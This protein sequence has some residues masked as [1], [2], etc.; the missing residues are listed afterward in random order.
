MSKVH[1]NR[2]KLRKMKRHAV[3]ALAALMVAQTAMTAVAA[4][5]TKSGNTSIEAERDNGRKVRVATDSNAHYQDK[6]EEKEEE[7]EI[8]DEDFLIDD[9]E[10]EDEVKLATDSNARP[11][12]P[13]LTPPEKTEVDIFEEMPEIGTKEFTDWFFENKTSEDLWS[14]VEG[15]LASEDES[16]PDYEAF[17]KW[18]QV[19]EQRVLRAYRDYS[20]M[21]LLASSTGDL[22]NGWQGNTNWDGEGT[23]AFPYE[24]NELSD[25]CGLSEMVAAGEDFSGKYF[26]LTGDIDLGN[27][28]ANNGNWNPIG[29]YQNRKDIGKAVTNKFAGN[30]DGAGYS[31]TGMRIVNVKDT[32]NN[33]G[34]FGAVEG[35]S[36][37]NLTVE[38]EISSAGDNVGILAGSV[39]EDT[40]IYNVKVEN[41]SISSEGDAGGLVGEVTGKKNAKSGTVTFENCIADGIIINSRADGGYVGGIAGNV[42]NANIV[43]CEVRTYDGNSDRIQGSGYIGGIAGRMR[44]SNLFNVYVDGTI[45]GSGAQ[46]VGGIVGK[47]ESGDLIL[48]RFAGTISRTNQGTA[49]RE[50]TFVGTRDAKDKFTYGV[51]KNDNIAY[52]FTDT[53]AKAKNVFG[54]SIDKDN[55]FTTDAHIGYWEDNERVFHLVAG[56]VDKEVKDKFFYEELED[57]VKHIIV[58]KH[59]NKVSIGADGSYFD[60]VDYKLDHFAPNS[61]GAPIKGYL[62]SIPR[63]DTH[64]ADGT[65]DSDVATLTAIGQTANSYYRQIDMNN[66]S[67]VAP[68]DT[69]LVGTAPKNKGNNKYQMVYDEM[70][71]GKVKPPTYTDEDGNVVDMAYQSGGSYTFTMPESD[72]ELNV[73]YIKVTTQLTMTP[74]ETTLKVVQ[75]R[76]GDRKNP[77]ITT[78]VYDESGKQIAKYLGDTEQVAPNPV[79]VTAT[80]NGE[81]SAN[82]RTV[83]WSIDNADLVTLSNVDTDTYTTKDAYIMPN[84]KS[85]F[86]TGIINKKVQEQVDS[87]YAEAIDNTVYSDVAT[88]TA[89]TNP[90]TSVNNIPVVGNTRVNVTF[91]IVDNTTRRVEGLNLNQTNATITVTRKL[92]GDRL[93]PTETIASDEATVLAASLYPE[94]P[95]N[96]NVTWKWDDSFITTENTGDHKENLSVSVRFDADGKANPAWIQNVINADNQKRKDDKYAKISGNSTMTTKVTATADDQTHGNVSSTCNITINFVT[97]D[98]TVVHPETVEM[99]QSEVKYDLSITKA[100]DINSKEIANKGFDATDLDATVNPQLADDDAHKPYDNT[101]TWTVSDAD[102]LTVDQNGNITPNKNAQWIK[103]AQKLAPYKATKTVEVYA[104][105]NDKTNNAVG[106]TVVTLNY[107]TNVVELPQDKLTY[108]ITLTKSGR[109]SSPNYTWAGGDAKAFKAATYPTE[110]KNVKYASSNAEIFTVT[111]DGNIYPV[112]NTDLQWV[113]DVMAKAPYTGTQTVTVSATDGTST[114]TA[115]ITLNLKVVDNTYSG[116][117]SGGGGGGSSSGGGGGSSASGVRPGGSTTATATGLPSYV[118]KGGTWTQNALGKW[119]YTNG[120]TFTNEWAAV[121]N[122]YADPKKGQPAYDWFR[123][124]ADSAMVTGWFTDEKGD[125]YYLHTVSDNTLGHMYTGWNWIDSDGDGK[126][127]CFYFNTVSDGTR[128]RL[129]KNTTTPDNYTVNEKGQWTVNG[130]VQTKTQEQLNQEAAQRNEAANKTENT[131]SSSGIVNPTRVSR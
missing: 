10:S 118:L 19:N 91:Q 34:L 18:Y 42:Q 47:Y 32:L 102:A 46:A 6:N 24:I 20:G 82:D 36:I 66:P 105:A 92:T 84:L 17:M 73:E 79:S 1:L 125:T 7:D 80:H 81:G 3:T 111:E 37:K 51:N 49:S 41:S 101:V 27:L 23:K 115:T 16:D 53:A 33:V 99:S 62:V 12:K 68:G 109:R 76:D 64:N 4:A 9:A 2:K 44:G 85:S 52:L 38:G 22:W 69:I 55:S 108:D 103:D 107:E 45:G 11:Q 119:F 67:A 40:N 28:T 71:Q 96:K 97:V 25:L 59:G 54:S 128:G 94:Q 114:D 35:G 123:F 98:E 124:G 95:F 14:W 61:Y 58:N 31:I 75:T 72:T 8:I 120:R 117:S 77:Q 87:G 50:G 30:F 130:V 57:A 29:W 116:G 21:Q 60:G 129:F 78:V 63:I 26:V 15:L 70:E 65:N 39:S 89:S 100:G 106:K 13:Q 104:T 93:N 131:S 43:D 110:D 86:I 74:A 113:K 48:A 83:I 88:L 90:D 112:L 121:Q 126:L 56:S 127:E 5:P 122:P